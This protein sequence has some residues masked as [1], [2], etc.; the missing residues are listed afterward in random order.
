MGFPQKNIAS[1]SK[2]HSN[3]KRLLDS[4]K[5]PSL[6]VASQILHNSPSSPSVLSPTTRRAQG[7]ILSLSGGRLTLAENC[8]HGELFK[9][10]L[11]DSQCGN[12]FW[13]SLGLIKSLGHDLVCPY[14]TDK[15]LVGFD[16][17]GGLAEVMR[18]VLIKGLGKTYFLSRNRLGE[19]GESCRFYCSE[20]KIPYDAS[21]ASFLAQAGRTNACPSCLAKKGATHV[22]EGDGGAEENFS[23]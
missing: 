18:F 21:F 13:S 11:Y 3:V 19:L 12:Y 2:T 9:H 5:I 6:M 14:C 17:I 23:S 10:R 7:E 16:Q 20:C 4:L 8:F 15:H 1:C 22:V